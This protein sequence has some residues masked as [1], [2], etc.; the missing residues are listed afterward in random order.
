LNSTPVKIGNNL[1]L[2]FRFYP[3]HD[4]KT[5]QNENKK[6][7]L[8]NTMLIGNAMSIFV[9]VTEGLAR[10][11]ASYFATIIYPHMLIN[12]IKGEGGLKVPTTFSI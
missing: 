8:S 4:K 12:H 11:A 5:G 9:I 2:D 3:I 6:F 10:L 7:I 1:A